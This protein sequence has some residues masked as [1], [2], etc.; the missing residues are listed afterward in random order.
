MIGVLVVVTAPPVL[1]LRL[2]VVLWTVAVAF[3]RVATEKCVILNVFPDVTT[4]V[5]ALEVAD[6]SEDFVSVMAV[7]VAVAPA[8]AATA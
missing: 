8:A 3:P 5:A 6:V 7:S 1:I 2:N 4:N